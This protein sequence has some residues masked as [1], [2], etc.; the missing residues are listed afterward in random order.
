[1]RDDPPGSAVPGGPF[2]WGQALAGEEGRGA[3]AQKK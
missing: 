2:A 3:H 1:M